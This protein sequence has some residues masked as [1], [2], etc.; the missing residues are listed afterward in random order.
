M[1]DVPARIGSESQQEHEPPEHEDAS[2]PNLVF[3]DA[4]FF[5]QNAR[6]GGKQDV[7]AGD[8]SDAPKRCV[9]RRQRVE[10]LAKP[11]G[12]PGKYMNAK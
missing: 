11:G 9:R 3:G 10:S 8:F 6:A 5:R 7:Q 2:H 12:N 1:R 4:E